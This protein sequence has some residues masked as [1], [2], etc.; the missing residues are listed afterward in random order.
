MGTPHGHRKILMA[1][2]K[3]S[4]SSAQSLSTTTSS[5]DTKKMIIMLNDTSQYNWKRHGQQ[6][7]MITE[8]YFPFSCDRDKCEA[9]D[10]LTAG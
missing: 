5:L 9:H 6:N 4:V 10:G 2:L 7:G 8:F 1:P 3:P